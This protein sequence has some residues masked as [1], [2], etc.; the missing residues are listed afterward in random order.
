MAEPTS[1]A[2]LFAVLCAVAAAISLVGLAGGLL[3]SEALTRLHADLP[4]ITPPTALAGFLLALALALA[5]A[6]SLAARGIA[7]VLAALLALSAAL[8]LVV[9]I[10][11]GAPWVERLA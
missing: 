1:P 8:L 2:R 10:T 4:A 6:P 9:W 11:D 5:V 7:L 3:G